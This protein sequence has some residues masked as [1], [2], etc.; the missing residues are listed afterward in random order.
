MW[1]E[2][3][4]GL[5]YIDGVRDC[6]HL[7]ESI[8]NE[9]FHREIYFP[10]RWGDTLDVLSEQVK[11]HQREFTLPV[12]KPIDGDALLMRTLSGN[13]EHI[14]TVFHI[15]N[16]EYI[17]HCCQGVGSTIITPTKKL[18]Y[19]GFLPYGYYRFR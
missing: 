19:I 2:N 17:I 11:E 6:G 14:G 13:I 4:I 10:A 16:K 3:Y 1:Y 18:K 5:P 8:Q 7:T 12:D 9:V 15:R